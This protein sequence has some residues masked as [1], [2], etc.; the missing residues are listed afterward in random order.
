MG[1]ELFSVICSR[2]FKYQMKLFV[3]VKNGSSH[4][5]NLKSN[6]NLVGHKLLWFFLWHLILLFNQTKLSRGELFCQSWDNGCQNLSQTDRQTDR[7]TNYLTPY[8]C[9]CGFFLQ[10][11]FATLLL[12]LL[13][14]GFT[15]YFPHM[16][17]KFIKSKLLYLEKTLSKYKQKPGWG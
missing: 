13:A 11:K 4:L 10:V 15:K 2:P 5:N 7:Q 3:E 14:R 1:L 8:T 9:V 12:A 16:L 6:N 17:L